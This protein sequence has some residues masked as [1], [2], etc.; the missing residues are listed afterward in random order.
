MLLIPLIN[1]FYAPLNHANGNVYSLVT[2]LDLL[3]P[4]TKYFIVPYMAWYVLIFAVLAWLM[5]Y[6]Y[7][8]YIPSLASICAGL[9]LSFLVY[10]VFQ[11][12]VPRPAILGQDLFSKLTRFMYK[13]DNPYNAF[14]SI[15]VMTACIIFMASGKAKG[16]SRKIGLASQILSILVIL[17]TVFLK[18]HTLMDVAGGVFLGTALFKSMTLI[19]S[20]KHKRIIDQASKG[21]TLK[22]LEEK[23]KASL[24]SKMGQV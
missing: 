7:D 24:V 19:Q 2:A 23:Y 13:L 17:S 15:H 20:L 1:L 3:I 10:T 21:I 22:P 9:I 16:C 6:D 12:T 4:F 18:Q 5:K 8:L 14:P 11:T